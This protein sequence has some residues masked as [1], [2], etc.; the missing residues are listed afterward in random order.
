[1]K[2]KGRK[3]LERKHKCEANASYYREEGKVKCNI[4]GKVLS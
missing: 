2:G 1:M 4:C 3:V